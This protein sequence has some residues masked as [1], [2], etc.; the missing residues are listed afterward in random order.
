MTRVEL[1]KAPRPLPLLLRT[2]LLFG[3]FS[4]QFGWIFLGFGLIF[5]RVFGG[6]SDTGVV[7]F[8][9]GTV[10]TAT[11]VVSSVELTSASEGGSDS[12]P[13]TPIYKVSYTFDVAGRERGGISYGA[14]YNPA[15]GTAVVVE[16]IEGDPET[17]RIQ[18]CR[19]AIFPIWVMFVAIFPLVGAVF[20]FFGFRKGWKANHLLSHGLLAWATRKSS[21]PTNVRINNRTVMKLTFEFEAA[22]GRTYPAVEKTHLPEKLQDDEREAVLYDPLAPSYA[23]MLDSLPGSPELTPEGGFRPAGA[24]SGAL[25]LIAPLATVV[26]H[27]LVWSLFRVGE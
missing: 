9:L 14:G 19:G 18:G 16:Y 24:V 2:Q 26:G 4:N 11:G 7:R 5:L 3:G 17:S 10:K 8:W 13:G 6:Y 12:S 23:V 22:D 21:E 1:T 15:P 25:V 27:G 20:V